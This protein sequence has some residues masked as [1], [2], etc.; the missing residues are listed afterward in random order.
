[1]LGITTDAVSWLIVVVAAA[2]APGVVIG[3]ACVPLDAVAG[4]A[5][6]GGAI[7]L[8]PEQL[9][10]HPVRITTGRVGM[11]H[12]DLG[13]LCVERCVV[14]RVRGAFPDRALVN[15]LPVRDRAESCSLD[16]EAPTD[17]LGS[18]AID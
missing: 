16:D 9:E 7:G 15:P 1:M 10:H 4:H 2:V 5:A 18:R 8:E 3:I 12:L 17:R 13:V 11:R 14:R 6:N